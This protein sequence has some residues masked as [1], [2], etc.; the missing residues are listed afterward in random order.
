VL[1][2]VVAEVHVDALGATVST[3]YRVFIVPRGQAPTPDDAVILNVDKSSPPTV[4]WSGPRA[5]TISC[6]S[7]RIWQFTNF[8]SVRA[9]D[10]GFE[11]GEHSPRL[12]PAGIHAALGANRRAPRLRRLRL[13]F[14]DG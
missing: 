4:T 11:S 3:P 12:R 1:D 9:A 8:A 5:A 14:L 13:R 6:E 10:G 2:A 7:A